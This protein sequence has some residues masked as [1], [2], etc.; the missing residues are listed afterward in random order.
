MI[1]ECPH[2]L[3][4]WNLLTKTK[5]QIHF[6]GDGAKLLHHNGVPGQN[7]VTSTLTEEYRLHQ[8]PMERAELASKIS[9]NMGRDRILGISILPGPCLCGDQVR[10]RS[11]KTLPISHA[12][13]SHLEHPRAAGKKKKPHSSDYW[14]VQD[15]REVNKRV[16]DIHATVPNPYNLCSTL[17]SDQQWYILLDLKGAFFSLP[18]VLNLKDAFFRLPLAPS[19]QPIL[20]LKRKTQRSELVAS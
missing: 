9:L 4:C 13:F 8:K 18:L 11:C 20:P 3:L 19:S 15:L 17:P 5:A 16:V 6:S 7:L 2:P 1:P 12:P 10:G 14:S